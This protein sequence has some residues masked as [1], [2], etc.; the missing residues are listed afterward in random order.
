MLNQ[1]CCRGSP[2]GNDGKNWREFIE[3]FFEEANV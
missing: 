2:G 3:N 1:G